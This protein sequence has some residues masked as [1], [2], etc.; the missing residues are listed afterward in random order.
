MITIEDLG[1]YTFPALLNNSLRQFSDL[2]ALSF[3]SGEPITYEEVGKKI[4]HF[5][6]LLYRSGVN[7]G[8]RVA[9]LGS[10]S[11][12]WAIAYFAITTLG[13]IAVP[14]LPDFSRNEVE[15][16]IRHAEATSLIVATR[17]AER[18]ENPAAL[19][20]SRVF[21]LDD[22]EML[23]GTMGRD[24]P[25]PEIALAESDTASIIYTSGTTGRSKG[26]ELSHKNLVF[27]AIQGQFFQRINKFDVGLSI[28]PM[29]H[30]YE[31]TIG[32][33]M[34]FINGA[35]IYYLEKPPTVTTL[36]PALKKVRPTIMLSVPLIMEKIY[37]NKIVP[38]FTR[39]PLVAALYRNP[40]F[41]K[42][43]HRLA[44]KSLRKTF[45]GRIKFFGIGGAK[46]DPVVERFMKEAKFPYAIGYGLTET[47]PLLAGSGPNITRPGTIGV[48]MPGVEL[49]IRN[50]DPETGV[51]E[52][53]ARGENVM[54]GY[55]RDPDMTAEVL[56]K[57]GWF[58]TGDLG[59]LDKKGRLSGYEIDLVNAIAKEAGIRVKIVE[60]PW[61]KL[62]V[63]LDRGACDAVVA[64]VGITEAKR[65]RYDFSEPYLVSRQVLVVR[66]QA[67]DEPLEQKNI[68]TFR[69]TPQA[70]TL[71][72]YHRCPITFYTAQETEKAFKDLS[73]G[74][75]DAVLC[76]VPQASFYAGSDARYKG[77]FIVREAPA[78]QGDKDRTEEY[79]IVVKKGNRRILDLINRGLASVKQKGID[80]K[81][82]DK[83]I[84]PVTPVK[85]TDN[86]AEVT[87]P[88]SQQENP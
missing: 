40:V 87:A 81:L 54:K 77:S 67:L 59:I 35:C 73:L 27:T 10:S 14:L 25:V 44:G 68:A 55:Y 57:D 6:E 7:K 41:R 16:C 84:V 9:L 52:V 19:S 86:L 63:E 88:S 34:F 37:K 12:N 49:E 75:V 29:S 48:I 17:L 76:E 85:G 45:G 83:W 42:L 80:R 78:P 31:F 32:F 51:G 47:S 28:L 30:V 72:L 53:V 11:P 26:V 39:K 8:D 69:L 3:V 5:R 23:V 60:R 71:R 2:P 15:S 62:F 46:V 56:D 21:R 4:D 65:E 82:M 18:V 38:T 50:P 1:T 22:L 79:G 20:V 61:G 43:F 36:L 13:A 33:L 24:G 70:E 74:C 64:Q 66:R 58:R